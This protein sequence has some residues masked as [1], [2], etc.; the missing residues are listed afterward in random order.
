MVEQGDWIASLRKIIEKMQSTGV[1]ELEMHRGDLRV[2]LR[3]NSRLT[4]AS[5]KIAR[6]DNATDQEK[7][8]LHQ[9]TAPLTGVFFRAPNPTSAP[10]VEVGDW[11]EQDTTVG[12]IETMKVFNE[13]TADCRGR[14]ATFL[15]ES[16]NLVHAGDPILLV[17]SAMPTDGAGEVIP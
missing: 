8:S 5:P 12:L 17:E 1:A 7:S 9:V 2:K 15:V 3:R 11:I 6:I 4:P 13:V 10:F 16:G 14:V